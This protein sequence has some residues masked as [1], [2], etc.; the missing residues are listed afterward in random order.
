MIVRILQ[1]SRYVEADTRPAYSAPSA[2]V[3][4]EDAMSNNALFLERRIPRG[5]GTIDA[6]DY[7][8]VGPAFVLMHGFPD[9]QQ[10][11]DRLVPYLVAAGRRVVTFDFLGYGA[12]D[13]PADASYSFRQQLGDLEAV[14]EFCISKRSFPSATMQA[15][16]RLSTSLSTTRTKY[17]LYAF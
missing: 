3:A 14:L 13:K 10:I 4:S 16:P 5:Q 7:E 9:N 11:Y 1:S 2:G 15:A 17:P 12:S 6:R 8:G